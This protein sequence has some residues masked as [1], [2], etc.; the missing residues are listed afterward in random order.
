MSL[1]ISRA[2]HKH[3]VHKPRKKKDEES[4]DWAVG[5]LPCFSSIPAGLDTKAVCLKKLFV[6]GLC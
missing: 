1:K 5:P 2:F 4:G 6:V 3:S